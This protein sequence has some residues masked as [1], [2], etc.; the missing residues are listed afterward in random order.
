M[1]VSFKLIDGVGHDKIVGDVEFEQGLAML[2]RWH[3]TNAIE[4]NFIS[5]V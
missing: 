5:L 1:P 3:R 2:H 4:F